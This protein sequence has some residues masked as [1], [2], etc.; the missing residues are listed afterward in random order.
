MSFTDPLAISSTI[1]RER[2]AR[3]LSGGNFFGTEAIA[4][5]PLEPLPIDFVAAE[6]TGAA[7]STGGAA[8]GAGG[9]AAPSLVL[10]LPG[11]AKASGNNKPGQPGNKS[12]GPI[13]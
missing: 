13:E 12:P 7:G 3:W 6:A 4:P 2:D 5:P 9:G 8:A 11:K 10:K 1:V